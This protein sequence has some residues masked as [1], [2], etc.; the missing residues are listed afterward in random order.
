[1]KSHGQLSFVI[2]LVG[3]GRLPFQEQG[4]PWA[5]RAAT[6]SRNVSLARKALGKIAEVLFTSVMY[7]FRMQP[8]CIMFEL[9]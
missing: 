3:K 7:W 2:L 5:E 8:L 9:D 1:M 4:L 6:P